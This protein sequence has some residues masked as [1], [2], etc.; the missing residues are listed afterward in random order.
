MPTPTTPI[1]STPNRSHSL[2][3]GK[4]PPILPTPLSI[5]VSLPKLAV[6]LTFAL[7]FTAAT[8]CTPT[9]RPDAIAPSTATG[10]PVPAHGTLELIPMD[11]PVGFP[12]DPERRLAPNQAPTPFT[13]EQIR[14]AC[15]TGRIN[16]FRVEQRRGSETRIEVSVQHFVETN[17][18]GAKI[19]SVSADIEKPVPGPSQELVLRWDELR[20]HASYPAEQTKITRETVTVPAGTYD[21]WLYTVNDGNFISRYWFAR[22]L[23]GP[24][25]LA[26]VERRGKLVR[27]IDLI[28]LAIGS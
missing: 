7:V 5:Q 8:G 12:S 20:A 28:D 13:S 19:K 16:R 14:L 18:I 6:A 1:R 2:R 4:R 17:D 27:K 25:I 26:T 9:K 23:A 3:T 11:L 21:C 24:P 10:T 15:P 22:T